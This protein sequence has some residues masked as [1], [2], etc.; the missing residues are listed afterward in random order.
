MNQDGDQVWLKLIGTL[1][2]IFSGG[3]KYQV[4][5]QW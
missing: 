4:N 1:S 2:L 5:F 3:Q